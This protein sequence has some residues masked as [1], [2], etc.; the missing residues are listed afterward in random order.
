MAH[1]LSLGE[2]GRHHP[3]ADRV[4]ATNGRD[5]EVEESTLRRHREGVSRMMKVKKRS[6]DRVRAIRDRESIRLVDC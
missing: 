3:G 5:I 6:V 4:Q 1:I 2:F